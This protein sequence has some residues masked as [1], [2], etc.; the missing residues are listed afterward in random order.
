MRMRQTNALLLL[1][2]ISGYTHWIRHRVGTLEH[3]EAVITELLEACIDAAGTPLVLN[4]LE[5]D[6]LLLWA[7]CADAQPGD[8][9]PAVLARVDAAFA[10]F[11]STRDALR[12]ARR[13]C[14]C[15]ACSN[16][17]ALTIKAVLH[18]GLVLV[19]QVRQFE[20][21][22]G[23]AVIL[24][25][26][27]LKND[28]AVDHYVLYTDAFRALLPD[29]LRLAHALDQRVDGFDEIVVWWRDEVPSQPGPAEARLV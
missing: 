22:A 26:R 28:V 5:G 13:H 1:L 21:L 11:A 25:H 7:D 3:A 16:I 4:K 6:A 12:R 14:N 18:V 10:R 2:D 29:D 23:E 20:E 9:A 24:A 15:A 8:V 19:K 27:L 17:D